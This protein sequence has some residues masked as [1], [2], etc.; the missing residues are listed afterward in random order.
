[1]RPP[2]KRRFLEIKKKK[3]IA[4][5]VVMFQGYIYVRREMPRKYAYAA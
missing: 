1:M 5:N 3:T 4:W 2:E